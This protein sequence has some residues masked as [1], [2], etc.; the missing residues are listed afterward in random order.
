[1]ETLEQTEV[2]TLVNL[3]TGEIKGYYENYE[4]GDQIKITKK[5]SIDKLRSQTK[6]G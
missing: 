1:M 5:A 6:W 4:D 3:S 2:L